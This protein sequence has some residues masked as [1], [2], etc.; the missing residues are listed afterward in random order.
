MAL[1]RNPSGVEKQLISQLIATEAFG[2]WHLAIGTCDTNPLCVLRQHASNMHCC[3]HMELWIG[4][5]ICAGSV[6]KTVGK[7]QQKAS[8]ML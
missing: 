5:K 2:R 6:E 7:L 8:F 3:R 4:V 1:R